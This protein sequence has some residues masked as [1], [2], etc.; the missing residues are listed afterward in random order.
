MQK[1]EPHAYC[2]PGKTP[3]S[4]EEDEQVVRLVAVHGAKYW[5][6]TRIIYLG[7]SVNSAAR[8]VLSH[9]VIPHSRPFA[10]RAEPCVACD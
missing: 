3:W 8:G 1:Q 4:K 6:T 9:H 5:P 2:H 7:V 10:R